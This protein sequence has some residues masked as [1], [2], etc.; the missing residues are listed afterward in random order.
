MIIQG[1][2]IAGQLESMQ[3][4]TT[5][6][7]SNELTNPVT[8]SSNGEF[9]DKILREMEPIR[10]FCSIIEDHGSQEGKALDPLFMLMYE[11][12]LEKV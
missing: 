12:I 4:H 8:K 2:K 3:V 7:T 1:S 5:N 6:P 11:D 9:E 10:S